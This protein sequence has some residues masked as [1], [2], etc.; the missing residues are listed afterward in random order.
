MNIRKNGTRSLSLLL[1]LTLSVSMWVGDFQTVLATENMAAQDVQDSTGSDANNGTNGNASNSTGSNTNNDASNN[2]GSNTNNDASNSTGSNT[3]NDA[4]NGTNNGT[5]TDKVTQVISGNGD[6]VNDGDDTDND[7]ENNNDSEKA[8][9]LTD[10]DIETISVDIYDALYEGIEEHFCE[11]WRELCDSSAAECGLDDEDN[12]EITDELYAQ[13]YAALYESSCT[14]LDD[15]LTEELDAAGEQEAYAGLQN[16]A[17]YRKV[18]GN[19]RDK[20][21]EEY[22]KGL[23]EMGISTPDNTASDL[24]SNS[25][26]GFNLADEVGVTGIKVTVDGVTLSEGTFDLSKVNVLTGTEISVEM[27]FELLQGVDE[28]GY[29]SIDNRKIQAFL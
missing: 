1:A 11:K 3:N 19:I 25:P 20:L 6:N 22:V 8:T 29:T 4:S 7:T 18:Y 27:N 21:Y 5:G 13:F 10:E 16:E 26:A 15:V 12:E 2:T 23:N 9:T 24:D 17:V 14:L 28:S